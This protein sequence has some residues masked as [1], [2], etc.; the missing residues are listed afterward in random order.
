LPAGGTFEETLRASLAYVREAATLIERESDQIRFRNDEMLIISNDRLLAPND[1][2][3]FA[4]LAPVLSK[5]FGADARLQHVSAGTKE[6]L[7]I[8]VYA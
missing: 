3:G 7:T 5:V 1:A 2:A 6:R 4:G 8:R